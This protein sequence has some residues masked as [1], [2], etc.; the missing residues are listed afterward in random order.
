MLASHG[1]KFLGFADI[2]QP[3]TG[4]G[5]AGAPLATC[6]TSAAD[7]TPY[8][9]CSASRSAEQ[10]ARPFNSKFP[11]LA[12][13]DRLSNIDKSNYNGLHV[14]LT[15][16]PTHGMSFLVGYTYSHALDNASANFGSNF[17]PVDSSNPTGMYGK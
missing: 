15:Q 1:T 8:D 11:Y 14:T 9:K 17:L 13:I 3:A 6:L 2:N 10:T 7:A 4:A 12:Q 16:R 5:W